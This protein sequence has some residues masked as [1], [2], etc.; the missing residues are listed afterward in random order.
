ME[1]LKV[2]VSIEQNLTAE[3]ERIILVM[4]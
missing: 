1:V 3:R 2:K 4:L